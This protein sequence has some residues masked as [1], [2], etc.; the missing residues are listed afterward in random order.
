MWAITE[1]GVSG[2]CEGRKRRRKMV[3]L[4]FSYYFINCCSSFLD[5]CPLVVHHRGNWV[6]KNRWICEESQ[7]FFVEYSHTQERSLSW[8]AHSQFFLSDKTSLKL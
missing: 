4:L 3:H 2:G 1:R 7:Q 5:T 8:R 6:Q